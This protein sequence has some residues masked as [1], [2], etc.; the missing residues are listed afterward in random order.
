RFKDLSCFKSLNTNVNAI[1]CNSNAL[2]NSYQKLMG[3]L[4][5]MEVIYRGIDVNKFSYSFDNF[6]DGF[7]NI[8]FLGGIP[9]YKYINL[10]RNLKGGYTLMKAWE[11]IENEANKNKCRLIFAG[12][13]SDTDEVYKWHSGLKYKENVVIKG[14]LTPDEV[15]SEYDKAHIV[16][17][18]S[19]EEG[20]PNVAL[21]AGSKGKCVIA[22]DVGG[23]PELIEDNVN[24][25]LVPPG[26]ENALA[27]KL[28]EVFLDRD[29]VITVGMNLR[30]KIEKNFNAEK[31]ASGYVNLYKKVL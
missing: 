14:R 5:E 19:L 24:G 8:L 31:F 22:S 29:R 2:K 15:L 18:P 3:E 16:V 20:M 17:V 9:D 4:S 11:I 26:D 10:A 28:K 30:K 7:V 1:G 27:Q 13:D 12:P 23:V 25:L 21:E 6:S